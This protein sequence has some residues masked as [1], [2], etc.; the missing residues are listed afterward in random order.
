MPSMF[1]PQ[2]STPSADA[3]AAWSPTCTFVIDERVNGDIQKYTEDSAQLTKEIAGRDEDVS[4]WTGGHKAATKAR[5][6]EKDCG[7]LHK[8]YSESVD[9]LKR[10]ITLAKVESYGRKQLSSLVRV[11]AL[12][13]LSLISKEV[14]VAI[15]AFL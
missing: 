8:Y 5:G 7:N 2:Y 12:Q 10:P 9:A 1:N 11:S 4:V 6:I 14:K 15:A 13:G 3:W